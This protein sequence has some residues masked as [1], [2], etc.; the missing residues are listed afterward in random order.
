MQNVSDQKNTKFQVTS[1]A[2]KRMKQR[3]IP[4]LVLDWLYEYGESNYDNR[5]AEK[6][7]FTKRSLRILKREI[8]SIIYRK[9][10]HLLN[11][12]LVDIDGVVITVGRR[13]KRINH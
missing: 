9:V 10:E 12:Y 7:F 11:C 2:E 4:P 1:H 13:F 6:L 3:G 5:G 8:G